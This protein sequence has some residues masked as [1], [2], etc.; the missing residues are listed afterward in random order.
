MSI[1]WQISYEKSPISVS[2]KSFR[3]WKDLDIEKFCDGL[4]LDSLDY[5][6]NDLETFLGDWLMK[7]EHGVE[8]NVSLRKKKFTNKNS[9]PW[10]SDRLRTQKR[11]VC[12]RESIWKKYGAELQWKAFQTER[13]R[14]NR[15]L[16][17]VRTEYFKK[18]FE[19]YKGNTKHLC[20]LVA[21]LTGCTSVNP[22][23]EMDSDE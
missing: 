15:I 13:S 18:E 12:S 23:P 10:Y 9:Q 6:M 3:N 22:L 14:Y 20:K 19:Q 7:I 1:V 11:M 2:T 16:N 5:T 21:K 8:D 17:A 4:N